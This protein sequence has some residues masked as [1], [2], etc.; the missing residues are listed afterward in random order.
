MNRFL[1][2]PIPTKRFPLAAFSILAT[3]GGFLF[4]SRCWANNAEPSDSQVAAVRTTDEETVG[5][6]EHIV[7]LLTK[8]GCNAGACHG[9]A[10]GRGGMALS[11]FGS[12]PASDYEEIV[13]DLQGRRVHRIVP[14]KS[15]LLAKPSG[16]IDHEGGVLIEQGDESWRAIEAWM[17][18]GCPDTE[19]T[20][21]QSL[22]LELTPSSNRVS[23]RVVAV[24]A[25]GKEKDVTSLASV[26]ADQPESVRIDLP[27]RTIEFQQPG[28]H[29]LVARYRDRTTVLQH[30]IPFP[31]GSE[32]SDLEPASS[33]KAVDKKGEHEVDRLVRHRLQQLKLPLPRLADEPSFLRRIYLDVLGRLPTLLEC[34]SYSRSLDPNKRES[35]IDD[36]LQSEE[37]VQFQLFRWAK[38]LGLRSLPKDEGELQT[39]LRWLEDK[40]R[41]DAPLH[42][43]ASEI[44]LALGDSR[45]IGSTYFARSYPDP[46]V[47]ADAF[48]RFFLGI[49]LSC[50]QCHDHP[51]DRW[52]QDDFHGFAAIFAKTLAEPTVR[53]DPFGT[54]V[55]AGTKQT[56]APSIPGESN[57]LPD[58]DPRK[59]L[60]KW[61]EEDNRF[62]ARSQVNWVWSEFMGRGL[63]EPID[64]IT[65]T[66][67][68][69]HPELL[70]HLTDYFMQHGYRLRP[71]IRYLL[72][73][74][75]YANQLSG[76]D[77]TKEQASLSERF[78]AR[79]T[80]RSLGA[81]V[82]GVVIEKLALNYTK[83]P[84]D[85]TSISNAYAQWIDGNIRSESLEILGRCNR[86]DSCST[87]PTSE[88][89]LRRELHLMNGPFL[90]TTIRAISDGW[91]DR[92]SK[93]EPFRRIIDEFHTLTFQRPML[94]SEWQVWFGQLIHEDPLEQRQ[95][96]EDYLWSILVS[97]SFRSR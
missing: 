54:I 68:G 15:L 86:Q 34:E 36:L 53:F 95:R 90:D 28:I 3:V 97:Q 10:A 13:V 70:D 20:P 26:A 62:L 30:A 49:Q 24:D 60:A 50:A 57:Y 37:F 84:T 55:H 45:T 56:A 65:S 4:N 17:L 12:R 48:G 27:N 5:F 80:R 94:D 51:L 23:Y 92:L 44:V 16:L 79:A 38:R 96:C 66:R 2:A 88:S 91:Q 61:L 87:T 7:P 73:S 1:P 83:P 41:N 25:A 40:I 14:N 93:G 9:A 69:D 42:K 32:T 63:V 8:L 52:T 58:D 31:N 39:H 47:R 11:L 77:L 43:M 75:T 81:E 72:R 21:L 76:R 18:A 82:Y 78:Y 71:L 19:P 89:T 64:A 74:Q 35:L 85:A 59:A 22:E 29:S 33:N 46:K 67:P 6:R